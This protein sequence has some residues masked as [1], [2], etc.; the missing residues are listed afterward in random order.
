MRGPL[1]ALSD[2]RFVLGQTSR[3]LTGEI[4]MPIC[5][6]CIGLKFAAESVFIESIWS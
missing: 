2:F 6:M 4:H 3:V 1:T 5:E